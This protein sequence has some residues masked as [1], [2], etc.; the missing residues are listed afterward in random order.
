MKAYLHTF[1][2]KSVYSKASLKYM[3]IQAQ[4]SDKRFDSIQHYLHVYSKAP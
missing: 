2:S 3:Y 1:N 4:N